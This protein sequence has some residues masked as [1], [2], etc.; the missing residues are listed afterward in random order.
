MDWLRSLLLPKAAATFASE[1]DDL[2]VFLVWLSLFF[3]VL[4]AGL[5]FYSVIKFRRRGPDDV[6]PHITHHTGL[7]VAWTVIPTIIVIGIFFWG[8]QGYMNLFVSPGDAMEVQVT[9]KKWLWA[10]EYPNGTRSINELHLPVNR[11]VKLVM[12]SEDVLHNFYVAEMRTKHDVVPG[13][14]TELW[15]QP[16]E[17]G[18]YTT[19]CAFYCGKG[20]SQMFAKVVV[21]DDDKFKE[22]LETGGLGKDAPPEKIGEL[23]YQN[24]GCNTCHSLDG[25]LIAGGGPSWKGIWGQEHKMQDDAV[26]KVDENY[27][28][29]SILQPQAHI[30]QGFQPIMPTYQGLLKDR[31]IQGVIAFLKTKK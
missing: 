4:I 13:R 27:V 21:E 15:F 12:S 23:V 22:W 9:G 8:F 18:T 3:F 11:P 30:V 17:E 25:S 2:F 16:N 24:K 29:E 14:Y 28:R 10:F 31:E 6:T 5:L 26:I 7:E 20:H 1:V 19:Q